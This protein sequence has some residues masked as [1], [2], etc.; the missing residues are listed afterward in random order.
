MLESPQLPFDVKERPK[1]TGNLWEPS[2]KIPVTVPVPMP[3]VV[4]RIEGAVH[5]A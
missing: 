4:V 3:V 5:G 2:S 1:A